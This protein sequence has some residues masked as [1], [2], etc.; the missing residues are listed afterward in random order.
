MYSLNRLSEFEKL[1]SKCKSAKQRKRVCADLMKHYDKVYTLKSKRS[2]VRDC[3][4]MLKEIDPDHPALKYI[5]MPA[6]ESRDYRENYREIV[7]KKTSRQTELDPESHVGVTRAL[8]ESYLD[9]SIRSYLSAAIALGS[10]TGRRIYS[11]ILSVAR[12][13]ILAKDFLLFSGQAKTREGGAEPYRIPTFIDTKLIMEVFLKLRT[14]K[15]FFPPDL[16]L[17]TDES[18][19]ISADE[20]Y[21]LYAKNQS[22]IEKMNRKIKQNTSK[23]VS[24][25]VKK[26]FN[27]K[28]LK[29]K[30]LRAIYAEI[31]YHTDD[32]QNSGVDKNVY[33]SNILGHGDNDLVTAQSYKSF[34][35]KKGR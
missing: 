31:C 21:R 11:E 35:I 20:H 30:N 2:A 23:E 19:R 25:R 12:F 32:I 5:G 34:Y 13:E 14:H 7:Y 28:A 18:H 4:N 22:Y 29:A 24:Q 26:H 27:N 16:S 9:G 3:R 6:D 33:F 10:A 17:L 8:L 15:N 1:I